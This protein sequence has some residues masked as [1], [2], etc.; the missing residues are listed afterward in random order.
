MTREKYFILLKDSRSYTLQRDVF[1]PYKKVWKETLRRG[2]IME[3]KSSDD[4]R[5]K[6]FVVADRK[7][8][9]ID[10]RL[11]FR[12]E[13]KLMKLSADGED[14]RLLKIASPEE[15]YRSFII[16]RQ[17]SE[18]QHRTERGVSLFYLLT[19]PNLVPFEL[20]R[21]TLGP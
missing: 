21:V 13:D 14:E 12:S 2:T 18:K 10:C 6:T 5:T 4:R 1:K 3:E 15:R 9:H 17:Y 20:S 8:V 11:L 16:Y 19:V 7:D